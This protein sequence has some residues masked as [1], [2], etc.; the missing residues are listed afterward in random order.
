M[1]NNYD[2]VPIIPVCTQMH[3]YS[4]LVSLQTGTKAYIY[5]IGKEALG[6]YLCTVGLEYIQNFYVI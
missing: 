3:I 2:I 4:F 6:K 1:E 5:A